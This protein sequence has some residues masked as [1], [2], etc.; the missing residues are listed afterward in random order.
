[1]KLP[2][3]FLLAAVPFLGLA[4]GCGDSS[5]AANPKIEANSKQALRTMSRPDPNTVEPVVVKGKKQAP[6]SLVTE[7]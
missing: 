4:A 5:Q 3:I 2:N 6:Q 7:N 1:M